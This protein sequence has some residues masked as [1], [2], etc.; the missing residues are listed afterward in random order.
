MNNTDTQKHIEDAKNH[1]QSVRLSTAEKTA[2]KNRLFADMEAPARATPVAKQL[3]PFFF[4]VPIYAFRTVGVALLVVLL[5]TT[6]VAFA[7]E[8]SLP[9]ELLYTVKTTITEPVAGVFVQHAQ[10]DEY[11]QT[12][13]VKRA[14]ELRVLA[15]RGQLEE[16][17]LR[18]AQEA[19]QNTVRDAIASV[20]TSGNPEDE[21]IQDHY[22]IVALVD[23]ALETVVS[24]PE[25][26]TSTTIALMVS[27]TEAT[28]TAS[29]VTDA[30]HGTQDAI[31][32][33]ADTLATL[34]QEASTALNE[35][36]I[37][38]IIAQ[39]EAQEAVLEALTED[40]QTDGIVIDT[41]TTSTTTIEIQI[42]A[43]VSEVV[44]TQVLE[45]QQAIAKETVEQA[46]EAFVETIENITEQTVEPTFVQ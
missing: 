27:D 37:D 1:Y 15:K 38:L 43:P 9:G 5:V 12:L 6:P 34:Q 23:A 11:Y 45:V 21:M 36:V 40:A 41:S 14:S 33:F 24:A 35:H 8:R 28:T 32:A 26:A 2:L 22:V 3:S 39:P 18:D 20:E 44:V 10:K 17:Q 7:A 29:S 30:E 19:L 25:V 46:I 42:E 16:K 4:R 13:L 31:D